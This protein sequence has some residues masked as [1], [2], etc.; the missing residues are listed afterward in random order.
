[1]STKKQSLSPDYAVHPGEILEETLD[2]REITK[3]EL[4]ARTGI[5]PKTISQI[6]N[7]KASISP[8]VA[9]ALER[10]L[11][12]SAETWTNLDTQYRLHEA[13][14][15][16]RERYE[17]LGDWAAQFPLLELVKRHVLSQSRDRTLAAKELLDFFAVSDLDSWS[18][19]YEKP[20][21][22]FRRSAVLQSSTHAVAAWLRLAELEAHKVD[23]ARYN[24]RNFERALRS[25]RTLT[26]EEPSLYGE[27]LR[28]LCAQSGV[29]V[30]FVP[31]LPKCRT[32]GATRWIG[33]S[34]TMIALSLRYKSDDQFWFS[35]FHEAG[36]AVLHG[37]DRVF[38]DIEEEAGD[39]TEREADQFARNRLLPKEAYEQ[40]TSRGRFHRNDIEEFASGIGIAAGIVIGALQHDKLIEFGWHNELKRKLWVE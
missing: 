28:T 9:V 22:L 40:F 16:D 31:E 10:S 35:F 29:A 8:E 6:V 32:S 25:I 11:G 21:A 2:A 4:A 26:L 18:A 33:R 15:R 17:S 27:K 30:V 39:E 3:Q 7:R 1:M 34:K 12:I 19:V 13:R 20:V 23:T 38:I 37:R 14:E 5:T 24:G 36:H